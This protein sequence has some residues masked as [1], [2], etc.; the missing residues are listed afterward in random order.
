[1]A[2]EYKSL[3]ELKLMRKAGLLVAQT[4]ALVKSS[5]RPG[6][7][8]LELDQ[9]AEKNIRDGGGIPSFKGYHGFPGSIC[10]SVN[11]EI[12]HGIP[13]ERVI[14]SGDVISVDCG[15]IIDGWHGDAAF[16]YVVE[17]V[18]TND[19]KLSSVCEGS[20]WRGI[21]A[22]KVGGRLTDI[23]Y[24]IE[25]YINSQG[26]YGILREYGGHGIGSEMHMEPHVL[27][28]GRKGFGAEL[29]VG[30]ALA[31]EPMITLGTERMRVMPDKWTVTSID[32]SRGAHW[33]HTFAIAPDEKLFVLTALDG[34]REKLS[35][36]G[37]EISTLIS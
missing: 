11:E 18:D 29:A 4:L 8:T 1:L 37:V 31:I 2:I 22:A 16:T 13:G 3:D 24:E 9:I 34:G 20:M 26:K 23:S 10:V 19:L 33:E 36:L 30:M 6:I 5:I 14:Q 27:N 25:K 32:K 21:A 7:T 35:E 28:Y 17:P 12:V 15:A